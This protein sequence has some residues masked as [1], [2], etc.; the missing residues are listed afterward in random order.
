MES[1]NQTKGYF[2]LVKGK[3]KKKKKR[4]KKMSFKPSNSAE[5]YSRE[6]NIFQA[7]PTDIGIENSDNEMY[8]P[9]S[10]LLDHGAIEFSVPGTLMKYISLKDT[11]LHAKIQILNTNGDNINTDADVGLVNLPLQTL[12][13]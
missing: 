6:L 1:E 5:G 13:S 9:V 8:R 11:R 3:K 2:R 12:F 10:N 7:K 4:E